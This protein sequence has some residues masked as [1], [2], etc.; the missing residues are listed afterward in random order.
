MLLWHSFFAVTVSSFISP[1]LSL[2]EYIAI[3]SLLSPLRIW[4]LRSFVKAFTVT[5]LMFVA[6]HVSDHYISCW[7][8][9]YT[10]ICNIIAY[11]IIYNYSYNYIIIFNI[12]DLLIIIDTIRSVS[13]SPFV[14]SRIL[15]PALI[16]F[17]LGRIVHWVIEESVILF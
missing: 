2:E 15:V 7:S 10:L 6:S 14:T 9:S 1:V 4:S 11:G 17:Y 12:L 13:P 8:L 5:S 16:T 3:V